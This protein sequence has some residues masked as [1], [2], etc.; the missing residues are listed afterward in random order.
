MT[1]N[2]QADDGDTIELPILAA[3]GDGARCT[4]GARNIE[5]TSGGVTQS[6]PIRYV[7]PAGAF[8]VPGMLQPAGT[9]PKP[10]LTRPG[11]S[12]VTPKPKPVSP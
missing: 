7:V 3:P 5:V 10:T 12:I 1:A 11:S 4:S 2:W 8:K 6:V 9:L